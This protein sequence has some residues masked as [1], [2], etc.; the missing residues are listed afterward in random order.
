[1]LSSDTVGLPDCG[2]MWSSILLKNTKN[3]KTI[4]G[5]KLHMFWCFSCTRILKLQNLY[6]SVYFK[7]GRGEHRG[8]YVICQQ[9]SQLQIL[10]PWRSVV[11]IGDNNTIV[12]L[13]R[14]KFL[15][16]N[17]LKFSEC[18]KI[19]RFSSS[20]WNSVAE[21]ERSQVMG[22]TCCMRAKKRCTR[23]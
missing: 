20:W 14:Y 7:E 23:R 16:F 3:K 22:N 5:I 17:V 1:M 18:E 15:P 13:L 10:E 8:S 9:Q 4:V 19:L 11:R 6:F 2:Q 21:W 12:I